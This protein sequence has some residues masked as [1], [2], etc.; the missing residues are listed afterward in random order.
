MYVCILYEHEYEY[1][2]IYVCMCK[3]I[4]MKTCEG[5]LILRGRSRDRRAR[6]GGHLYTVEPATPAALQMAGSGVVSSEEGLLV[7]STLDFLCRYVRLLCMYVW[8]YE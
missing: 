3:N 7:G 5:S 8:K 1:I 4:C 6:S 2:R